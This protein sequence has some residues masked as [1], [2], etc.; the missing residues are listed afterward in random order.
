[1]RIPLVD[2]SAQFRPLKPEIMQAIES[3]LDTMQLFL[4]PHTQ[5]FEQEF[6]SYCGTTSCT[7]VGNGTDALHLALR[8]AGVGQGDEVITVAH[9]FFATTEAIVMAGATPVYVDI[10]PRTYLMDVDQIEA[11]ISSRTR[12]IMP[13]HLYG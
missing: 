11:R 5:A 4:G 12:A 2:L 9:T 10:D 13:V 7:T 8:S 3:V 1:M 6:A